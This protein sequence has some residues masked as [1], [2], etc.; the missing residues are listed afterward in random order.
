M[1]SPIRRAESPNWSSSGKTD[2]AIVDELYFASL[3]R[4]PGEASV[5]V[6]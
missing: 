6:A 1:R 3:G 5:I 4:A 2:A